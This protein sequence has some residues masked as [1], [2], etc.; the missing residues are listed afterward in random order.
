MRLLAWNIRYVAGM[1]SY[2]P[3]WHHDPE[4]DEGSATVIWRLFA[5]HA[6][7]AQEGNQQHWH[8]F[9]TC[10]VLFF[11]PVRRVC[12]CL[13]PD[14]AEWGK[15]VVPLWCSEP[16]S[17]DSRGEAHHFTRTAAGGPGKPGSEG[18]LFRPGRGAWMVAVLSTRWSVCGLKSFLT[19]VFFRTISRS[20][21][22]SL[23]GPVACSQ[24]QLV[25]I[26]MC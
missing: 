16:G 17:E 24:V 9:N 6:G 25:Y 7:Q 20:Y 2:H 26:K 8:R 13:S 11:P 5:R 22:H 23:T 4:E 21:F 3:T 12:V 1:G 10:V 18:S 14:R 19:T 15:P